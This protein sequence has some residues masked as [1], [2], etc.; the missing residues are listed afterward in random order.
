MQPNEIIQ[1]LGECTK[2]TEE[3]CSVSGVAG[4]SIGV[5]H[6]GQVIYKS[7]LGFRDIERALPATPR[8][9]YS[10][11]SIS[12]AFT[13]SG[14]AIELDRHAGTF[15]WDTS[16]E[17]ILPDF[18][19]HTGRAPDDKPVGGCI[20]VGDLLSHRSGLEA[21]MSMAVQGSDGFLLSPSDL[22]ASLNNLAQV[23]PPRREWIY[24]NWGYSA[25]GAIIEKLSGKPFAEYIGEAVLAPLGLTS[26]TIKP[27]FGPDDNDDFAK[28]YIALEDGSCIPHG[29][30]FPFR[31]S[32]FE[33]AGGVCSNVGDLLTWSRAVL[34][35]EADPGNGGPLRGISTLIGNQT[36]L[37]RA[38]A[39]GCFYGMGWIRAHLPGVAGLQGES[40]ALLGEHELPI[41][42]D[43]R[44]AV[45][46]DYHQSS[47]PG[48]SGAIYLFPGSTSAV[49]VLTNST[50]LSD[51]VN[52]IAQ[53]HISAVFDFRPQRPGHDYR[54]LA[55]KSRRRNVARFAHMME[56]IHQSRRVRF[57]DSP[58]LPLQ[59]YQGV[60]THD[61]VNFHMEI[62]AVND[63]GMLELRFQGKET[64]AF[65]LR[66]LACDLFEWAMPYD[67]QAQ[68]MM[69]PCPLPEYFKV[70]F[71]LSFGIVQSLSWAL[72]RVKNQTASCSKRDKLIPR[73][74]RLLP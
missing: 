26:T 9:I 45:V 36:P 34:R 38:M 47:A 72:L 39:D 52:W 53:A 5:M 58:S 23:A 68:R 60:Y 44:A 15:G 65:A 6:Q 37:G 7:S 31:D 42:G 2:R 63:D 49:M 1:R 24:N 71:N 29:H 8:T 20:P 61:A 27:S 30:P 35:A 3:I 48:Y 11:G 70:R 69:F 40:A 57:H 32:I 59:N 12:K 54:R 51:A 16:V 33:A 50:A 22:T 19:P 10:L 66:H 14:L 43:Q 18:S 13:A 55:D 56:S 25:A 62:R 46:T 67:E 41:L 73:L 74:P 64:Q 21:D 17:E 28:P 4:V